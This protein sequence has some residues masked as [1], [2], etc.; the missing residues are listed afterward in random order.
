MAEESVFV[1][2]ATTLFRTISRAHG[3]ISFDD[4]FTRDLRGASPI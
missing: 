4:P 1:W 2:A 3:A